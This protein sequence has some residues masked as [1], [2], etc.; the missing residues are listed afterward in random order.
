[1]KAPSRFAAYPIN[2]I[3][4]LR[5]SSECLTP[6]VEEELVTIW[7]IDHQEPIMR[8]VYFVA[9]SLR[10]FVVKIRHFL[11]TFHLFLHGTVGLIDCGISVGAGCG[12]G[13][14]N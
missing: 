11:R 14:R 6:I 8:D 1:M 3:E 13:I 5:Q 12:V 2:E 10:A 7:V 4:I 9:G